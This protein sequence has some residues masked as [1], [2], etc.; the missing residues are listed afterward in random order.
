MNKLKCFPQND[1]RE[2]EKVELKDTIQWK[3]FPDG[4]PNL[5]IQNVKKDCAGRNGSRMRYCCDTPSMYA[6]IRYLGWN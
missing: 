5:F 6:M 4:W 3:K 2:R 1:A